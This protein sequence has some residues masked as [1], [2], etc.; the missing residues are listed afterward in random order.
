MMLKI[1]ALL[2]LARRAAA[3]LVLARCVPSDA[4]Q[5]FAYVPATQHITTGG[6]CLQV[7]TGCCGGE[8][9]RAGSTLE[10]KPC[11]A[12]F[13]SQKLSWP[14]AA[15]SW[16]LRPTST[17]G[18]PEVSALPNNATLVFNAR[19]LFFAGAVLL[20]GALD[21]ATSAFYAT[22]DGHLVN[23]NSGLCL[24]TF[25]PTAL[26]AQPLNLQP[27]AP[28]KQIAGAGAP[29]TQLFFFDAATRRALTS[30]ALCLT[31]ERPLDAAGSA[32]LIGASCAHAATAAETIAAQA[33]NFSGGRIVA[34]NLP[35]APVADAGAGAWRG[36]RVPLTAGAAAA[37]TSAFSWAPAAGNASLGALVHT[38]T[39]MCL[40]A[41]GVPAGHSCLDAA[42]RG[43]PFCD[44]RLPLAARLAD[45]VGRLTI[46][47]ASAMTG[48]AGDTNDP[49][50]SNTAG[51]PRLDL[52]PYRW[53][54]EVSSMAG[55]VDE[56]HPLVQWGG[57]CPT[58]F[59]AAMLLTGAFNRTMW[60]AHGKVVGDEMRALS[61]FAT[62]GLNADGGGQASLAGH[63][64][65]I[66]QPVRFLGAAPRRARA[67]DCG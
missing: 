29:S 28:A 54:V 52:S 10:V 13:E 23:N 25:A 67:R 46:E 12:N 8:E 63:G 47:E 45:L 49:C 3:S 20:G 43:L 58:S 2:L 44:A 4:A 53:L 56:C 37:P 32:R 1:C 30:E 35:G 26:V 5:R 34:L 51:V 62:T 36:A 7:A 65:D 33:F 31:A 9:I 22:P 59:P 41:G 16:L 24:S 42:V 66:N 15:T 21:A 11:A 38:A 40:D 60:R 14:S 61:N 27:C 18:E 48:D 19:G 50:S 6:Q 55:S 17:A 39:G 57:G 64:P